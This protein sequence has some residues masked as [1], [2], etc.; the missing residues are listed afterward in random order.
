MGRRR[1]Q[2][3]NFMQILVIIVAIV[4]WVFIAKN[5]MTKW[6]EVQT[7][8]DSSSQSEQP[9]TQD[10]KEY[11]LRDNIETVLIMG[12]DKYRLLQR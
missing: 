11:V 2:G 6:N 4:F 9:I 8:T 3:L 1:K 5:A 10:G 7:P 12:L